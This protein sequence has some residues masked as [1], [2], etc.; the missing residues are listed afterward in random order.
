M[1]YYTQIG[2]EFFDKEG[3]IITSAEEIELNQK[4]QKKHQHERNLISSYGM[5]LEKRRLEEAENLD[6]EHETHD[7]TPLDTGDVSNI[8]THGENTTSNHSET[9][10][11]SVPIDPSQLIFS[12]KEI[13]LFASVIS[14]TDAV[15]ALAFIKEDSDPKLFP[16]LFGEG[17]VNDAVC[18]VLYQIIK[19]FLDSGQRNRKLTFSILSKDSI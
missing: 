14:A 9:K 1:F 18:I 11:N 3:N 5:Y 12:T 15:A 6:S 2:P 8:T 4:E 16:I 7:S 10:E 13:L 19:G 17:V